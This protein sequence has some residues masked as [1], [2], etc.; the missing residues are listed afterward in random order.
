MEPL[1]LSGL[2]TFTQQLYREAT[3]LL[4]LGDRSNYT[5]VIYKII[6]PFYVI[7]STLHGTSKYDI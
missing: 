7:C 5:D 3:V 1:P 6:N 4:N 2:P